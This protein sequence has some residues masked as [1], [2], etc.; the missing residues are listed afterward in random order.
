MPVYKERKNGKPGYWFARVN[1]H[2]NGEKKSKSKHYFTSKKEAQEWEK[3]YKKILN[4][5]N[6]MSFQSLHSEYMELMTPRLKE[7]TISRKKHIYKI[8]IYPFFKN[9]P[10][11][12]IDKTTI[13]KWQNWILKK[14]YSDTYTKLI[15]QELKAFFRYAEVF[16]DL[17][18]PM[19]GIS[20]IGSFT[21]NKDSV[22]WDKEIFDRFIQEVEEPVYKALFY[23]FFY[24]GIRIGELQG[25][26][27]EDI[28]FKKKQIFIQR[29]FNHVDGKNIISTPKTKTSIRKI[30]INDTLLKIL[31]KYKERCLYIKTKRV[32]N[33]SK[34]TINR[35]LKIYANKADVP[36]ITPHGF[37]HSHASLLIHMGV[38]IAT[39]SKR[40]G[41]SNVGVTMQIYAH[42]M[43]NSDEHVAKELEN[44]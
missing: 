7:T 30:Y 43:P 38:D 28:D 2:Q 34:S 14:N 23:T 1:Y 19:N 21:K 10:L 4:N 37:R 11:D 5:D 24:T 35:T 9:I 29:T 6:S 36:V 41:H 8:N 15:N 39:I 25:L 44:L 32:F 20:S 40:L 33:V 22:V 17:K 16:K 18:N 42:M 27:W 13:I 12:E 3:E 26:Y 31:K